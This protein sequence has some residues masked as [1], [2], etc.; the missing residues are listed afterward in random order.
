MG[1]RRERGGEEEKG[2]SIDGG[3][4]ATFISASFVRVYC[5]ASP[6]KGFYFPLFARGTQVKM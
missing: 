6:S 3:E 2:D 5:L 4:R 1:G